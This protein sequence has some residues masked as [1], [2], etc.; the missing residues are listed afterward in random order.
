MQEGFWKCCQGISGLPRWKEEA[1]LRSLAGLRPEPSLFQKAVSFAGAVV[2][3]VVAGLPTVTDEQH[4][5]R[6]SVCQGCEQFNQDTA[7]CRLCGCS[8]TTKARWKEQRCPLAKWPA[9]P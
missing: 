6:M 3:H 5:A 1:Y 4:A 8:M 7:A 2:Q 9:V